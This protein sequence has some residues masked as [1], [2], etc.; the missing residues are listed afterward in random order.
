MAD[1]PHLLTAGAW[2]V[3]LVDDDV[4]VLRA[5]AK[6]LRRL[7]CTV[8]T[9][10]SGRAALDMLRAASFDLIVSDVGMTGMSGIEFLQAVRAQ[11]LDVPVI[12]IT[13]DPEVEAATRAVD[14]GAF[15]YF[16]KPVD[17][18]A[19]AQAVRS[20]VH[21][22]VVTQ[23]LAEHAPL[24]EASRRVMRST[25]QGVD[26]DF[27]ALWVP[28][29]RDERLRCVETWARPC[30]DATAFE[31][32]TRDTEFERGR[33]LPGRVW[34]HRAPEWIPDLARDPNF[35][36]AASADAAGLRSGFAVPVGADAEVFAVLEFFSRREHEPDLELLELFA[37][38]GAQL[39]AQVLRE[40]AEQRAAGAEAGQQ[41]I[42]RMLD[43]IVECAPA[44]ITA[45]DEHGRI[46]FSNRAPARH[47]ED[48]ALGADWLESTPPG[49]HEQQRARLQRVLAT[50]VG[51]AYE[52]TMAGRDGE[53]LCHETHMAPLRDHERVIG[54]VL[55]SRDVTDFKHA[56]AQLAAA[57]RLAAVGTLAAGVAHEI[58]TPVQFVSDSVRFL[59]D[60][61]HDVFALVEKLQEVC[62]IATDPA[63]GAQL[64]AA[65]AAAA[66][67]EQDAD[68]AYLHE[69]LPKA[70]ERCV[71]GL[72][73]V[74]A[75]VRSMKEFAHPGGSHMAPVDLNRAIQGTLTIAAAEYKYVATLETDFGELP[76]V[77][78]QAG[79]INQVVLNL[80]VN[81]AHAIS[82]AVKGSDV[83][84]T[85]TV[86]TRVDGDHVVLS[87]RDTGTGIP[88]AIAHRVFEQFFTTKEVGRGTGQ[89]LALAWAVVTDKHGG[90]LRFE[91]QLGVGT[92]FFVRLPIAGKP[93]A[94]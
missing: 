69:S 56:Q 37:T 26:W 50:G 35:L 76:L 75:I 59:R 31:A 63:A 21:L 91:S 67:A 33:G 43:A 20:A 12:L 57:Q 82:D 34:A 87:I 49:Q 54:A 80:I 61:T 48:E 66:Q 74:A 1:D 40:R 19:L 29:G 3:L 11:P 90:E 7:G 28:D 23:A 32:A 71:D 92:T 2:R 58:N 85:L 81:A 53:T 4:D 44:F 51:E 15:R 64:Q 18:D 27:A 41:R 77:T 84:G 79:E 25:C 70:F 36:R 55:V 86:V 73:R 13:G 6:A 52:T 68:L 46:Q 65:L 39:G 17:L 24:L 22:H 42:G 62:R 45:V 38:S 14:Y 93:Q 8:E 88:D 30:Q 5:Y 47:L 10:D 9:V 16:T 78:C 72:G 89:G 60:A 83:R 94:P